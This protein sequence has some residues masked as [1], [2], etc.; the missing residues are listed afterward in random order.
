MTFRLSQRA[1]KDLQG[2]A[3]FTKDRW[4][5][6]QAVEYVSGLY[7]CF[8]HLH[9]ASGRQH[10]SGYRAQRLGRHV[11]FFRLERGDRTFIVRVL[12]ERMLP[13]K[14]LR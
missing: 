3:A 13:E 7:A 12:H 14:H 8:E 2:I 4:G 5:E 9:A 6:K 11:I 1:F 10:R